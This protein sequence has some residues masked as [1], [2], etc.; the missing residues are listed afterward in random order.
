MNGVGGLLWLTG[1][2]WIV[3]S[4]RHSSRRVAAGLATAVAVVTLGAEGVARHIRSLGLW[5]AKAKNV[6]ELSRLLLERLW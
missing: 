1:A 2:G 3:W 5:Q 6:V 4:L